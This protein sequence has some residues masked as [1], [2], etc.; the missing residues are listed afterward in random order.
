MEVKEKAAREIIKIGRQ[1]LE[2]GLVLGTWGNLSVRLAALD[3]FLITP[4]GIDYRLLSEEDLVLV[5]FNG[6]KVE[7]KLR[8]S[9]ETL[10]HAAIYRNR[11]DVNGIVHT[12]SIHSSVFAVNREEIPPVLE[13]FAQLVGGIVRVATY[14]PPG[15]PELA[16]ATVAAL[17]D[18]GAVLLAN[19]G[20]VS[21]GS[22]LQEA[23]LVSQVVEKAAY[24]YLLAK[25]SG[26]P[27]VLTEEEAWRLRRDFLENYGQ[28]D[29]KEG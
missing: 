28:K 19:H 16:E 14:A 10:L 8:P 20:L 3:G 2:S 7:G 23:F 18:R 22:H 15:T 5:D 4:S 9:S 21:V 27:H 1:M 29:G 26:K 17:G 12:H 13:E 11:P 6:R 24:V 25:I